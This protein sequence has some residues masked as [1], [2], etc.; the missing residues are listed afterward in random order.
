MDKDLKDAVLAAFDGDADDKQ[1]A[2]ADADPA[3]EEAAEKAS[4]AAAKAG[5]AS[6]KGSLGVAGNPRRLGTPV[7]PAGRKAVP[8][9]EPAE[10]P[11][12]PAGAPRPHS[13]SAYAPAPAAPHGSASTILPTLLG[14]VLLV[15]VLIL[16]VQT[17]SLKAAVNRQGAQLRELKGMEAILKDVKNLARVTVSVYQEPGKRPQKVIAVH[18]LGEDGV[19]K[20]SK[21]S[22]LPLEEP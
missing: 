9:R 17:L 22:I 1:A 8:A 11:A 19:L 16:L 6:K 14:V 4:P 7:A 10:E 18:E 12:V 21:L 13:A 5:G 15:L 2:T 3:T 20:L